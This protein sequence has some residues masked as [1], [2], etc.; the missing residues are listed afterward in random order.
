MEA[1]ISIHE[2]L[3]S[4]HKYDA[5]QCKRSLFAADDVDVANKCP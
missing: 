1:K 2:F 5:L 3:R 4:L